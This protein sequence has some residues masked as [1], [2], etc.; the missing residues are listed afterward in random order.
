MSE[1]IP[2]FK[3]FDINSKSLTH[4]DFN[5]LKIVINDF[6][7][8]SDKAIYDTK[9][10]LFG[11]L[12]NDDVPANLRLSMDVPCCRDGCSYIGLRYTT[13]STNP[14][15]VFRINFNTEQIY[16]SCVCKSFSR[17]IPNLY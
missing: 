13:I 7:C 2:M 16:I 6:K 9:K 17:R 3:N 10:I 4:D 5:T 1:L 11:L 14:V 8:C 12:S 15:F